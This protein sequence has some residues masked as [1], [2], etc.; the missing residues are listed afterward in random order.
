MIQPI[1]NTDFKAKNIYSNITPK[2]AQYIPALHKYSCDSIAFTGMSQASEYKTVFDFLAAKILSGN[3]SYN[4]NSGMLSASKIQSA[5]RDLFKSVN[6]Y[7][8]F[9]KTDYTKIKW[10]N[11]IPMDIRENSVDKINVARYLRLNQWI[12]VLENTGESQKINSE[13][14][15]KLKNNNS[16]KFVIWHAI[17]SE[18]KADNRHIPVPF[19]EDALLKTINR[20]E[21]IEPIDRNVTCAKP[22]F[23]EYYTH[24]L[25]DNLLMKMGLSNNDEVWVKIPSIKHDYKNRAT[26]IENLEILSNKNWCTRSSDDK[27]ADALADGDFYIY[28]KR[29]KPFNMWE[30]MV[31]MTSLKGKIDQIQ[32]KENDNI[33]PLNL[34]GKIKEFIESSNLKF[35][36]G[37]LDE[38]PKAAQ[39]III[40]EKLNE[41]DFYTGKT[42]YNAIKDNDSKSIF[43]ILGVDYTQLNNGN[44]KIKSY[45]PSYNLDLNH[46]Y[47][48]PY[49]MFGINEDELL[50]SVQ[51]IDGN[52]VLSGKNKL[53]NSSITKFPPNLKSVT[54]KV[55]CNQKQFAKYHDDI[56]RV[57][58]GQKSKVI[59]SAY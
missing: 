50:N 5:M 20:Y 33:V 10:K 54:G 34:V 45:K 12:N 38:G 40:S 51:I 23:I 36:S 26:N 30:P 39:A 4:V 22:S 6:I 47:I 43:G 18:L 14:A 32:G 42:L 2:H 17:T 15:K 13:L 8:N 24:R 41:K 37:I 44:L 56:M 9:V 1:F 19:N 46:G 3:K 29:T 21:D 57:V 16:L 59:V 49:S 25:R 55:I 52:F 58:G 35:Q 28:L 53:F 27:A 31:G 7:D 48:A 11:Y